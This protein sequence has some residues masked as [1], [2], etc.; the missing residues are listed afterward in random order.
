MAMKNKI[1]LNYNNCSEGVAGGQACSPIRDSILQSRRNSE[2]Y[3]TLTRPRSQHSLI[4][5][6]VA[7]ILDDTVLEQRY[8]DREKQ[9][10]Q[11][12]NE[13]NFKTGPPSEVHQLMYDVD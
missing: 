13:P 12:T 2:D 11:M 4:V 8:G 7:R 9:R 5:E 10:L 6:S 1:N 3:G